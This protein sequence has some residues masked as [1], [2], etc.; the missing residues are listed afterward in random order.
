MIRSSE[1]RMDELRRLVFLTLLTS[2][3][4]LLINPVALADLDVVETPPVDAGTVN[5]GETL[6]LTFKASYSGSTD[7]RAVI[8]MGFN[9]TGWTYA[10]FTAAMGTIDVSADF[11]ETI[12]VESIDL[13]NDALEP[14]EE[15]LTVSI[16]FTA[17]AE[18]NYTF[19]WSSAF[20]IISGANP[21]LTVAVGTTNVTIVTVTVTAN[22]VWDEPT[23]TIDIT[24]TAE[25]NICGAITSGTVAYEI[26]TSGDVS[27]GITGPMNY[28]VATSRWE[29]L[30]VDTSTLTSGDYY[31]LVNVTDPGGHSGTGQA[32]FT[33]TRVLTYVVTI[34][35]SGLGSSVYTTHVFV[36]GVDQGTPYI[37]D[38]QS[39]DFVF[40]E[41]E[42]HT[43]SVDQYVVDGAGARYY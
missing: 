32:P 39:R 29:A 1:R 42:A 23:D 41:G 12:S 35:T 43:I 22:A 28:N 18:G 30:D 5:V 2:L 19:D 9:S 20:S 21:D 3:L 36:D 7:S 11:T 10:G 15:T 26:F 37:W 33:I 13:T 25:C 6:T 38:G 14:D 24:A 16:N 8:S 27:T 34:S 31:A 17:T 40:I 4:V